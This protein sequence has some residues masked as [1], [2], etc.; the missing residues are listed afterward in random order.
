MKKHSIGLFSFLLLFVLSA[1]NPKM[2]KSVSSSTSEAQTTSTDS[3]KK[4]MNG[5]EILV[6]K[7]AYNDIYG[8]EDIDEDGKKM[9]QM[10]FGSMKLSF[11]KNNTY[12][13]FIMDKD[14]GGNWKFDELESKIIMTSNNSGER[15][16]ITVLEL[17]KEKLVIQLEKAA[18]IMTRN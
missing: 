9:L 7:W 10:F 1:C 15:L 4:E 18:F 17:T 16:E 14:D 5:K 6:G 2:K 8:K 11:D 13:A 12:S 3:P